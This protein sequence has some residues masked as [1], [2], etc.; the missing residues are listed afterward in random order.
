MR[1]RFHAHLQVPDRNYVKPSNQP[2][3]FEEFE[4]KEEDE[5]EENEEEGE[6]EDNRGAG[7]SAD[8]YRLE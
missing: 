7:T 5:K 1:A 2:E 8:P 6:E 3:I 4:V